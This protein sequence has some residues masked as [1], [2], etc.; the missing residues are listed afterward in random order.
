MSFFPFHQKP[1]CLL[2]GRSG[3]IF[4]PGMNRVER[5]EVEDTIQPYAYRSSP[6]LNKKLY[7][8]LVWYY[9]FGKRLEFCESISVRPEAVS[10]VGTHNSH[11][12]VANEK[13]VQRFF[14]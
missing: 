3:Y 1:F 8:I 5:T 12:S 6:E 11:W 9:T 4:Y 7:Y 2:V 10:C 14:N 13:K